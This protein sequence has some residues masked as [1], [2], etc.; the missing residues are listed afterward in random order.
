MAGAALPLPWRLVSPG[1][2]AATTLATSLALDPPQLADAWHQDHD[3]REAYDA[4]ERN[5]AGWRQ[6]SPTGGCAHCHTGEAITRRH[7][8]AAPAAC[9]DWPR[10]SGGPRQYRER[11]VTC[12]R[13]VREVE[14][15]LDRLDQPALGRLG[16]SRVSRVQ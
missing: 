1:A 7:P 3:A 8:I 16:P 4:M 12:R 11:H 5:S 13:S 9:Q 6:D 15:R 10:C 14:T 2:L